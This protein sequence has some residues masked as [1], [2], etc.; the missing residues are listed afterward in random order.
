MGIELTPRAAERVQQ[1][2]AERG[3]PATAGLRVGIKGGGCSGF[4]YTVD[5]VKSPRKFDMPSRHDKVFVSNGARI[6]VDKKS[7]LF[8]DGTTIDWKEEEFGHS[9]TYEN[10]NAKGI[11][12]CGTSFAV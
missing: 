8:L 10:P 11:C 4:E 12:G 7:L 3:L 5:L 2:L 9:F 6:L 1:I